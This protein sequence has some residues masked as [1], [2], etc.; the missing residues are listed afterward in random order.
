MSSANRQRRQ[1]NRVTRK[2]AE[3]EHLRRTKRQRIVFGVGGLLLALVVA[4]VLVVRPWKGGS[5]SAASTTTTLGPTTT[6]LPS[7]AGKPCVAVSD[8]LPSGAPAVPVKVGPPP[9]ALVKQDLKVGTGAVVQPGATVTVDYV[10]VACSTGKIFDSSY[11][12]G[13]PITTPLSGVVKGWQEGI[14][15]MRVGGTRLL[16]LPPA[17]AY[18]SASPGAGIAPNETLWFLV[19]MRDTKAAATTTTAAPQTGTTQTSTT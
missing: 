18:G 8:P 15:G 2:L 4:L 11:T 16:G 13:Q 10:G 14:P 19:Q 6:A 7:A 3:E 12:S 9:S 5:D 17:L 1:Q